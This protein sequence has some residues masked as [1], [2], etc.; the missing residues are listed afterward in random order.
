[1]IGGHGHVTPRPD[2]AK[3]RCGGPGICRECA[4]EL[5][6][7]DG[8]SGRDLGALML[9]RLGRYPASQCMHSWKVE[10]R[11]FYCLEPKGHAGAHRYDE[12]SVDEMRA[13]LVEEWRAALLLAE[14]TGESLREL[15]AGCQCE[16]CCPG[17]FGP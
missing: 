11:T 8:E 3:A 4:L 2:G 10:A 7:K 15:R 17:L 16:E 12:A 9:E 6:R 1:M 14:R 5:A 13:R